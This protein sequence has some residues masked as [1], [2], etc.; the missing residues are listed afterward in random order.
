MTRATVMQHLSF[1]QKTNKKDVMYVFNPHICWNTK[2]MWETFKPIF[3]K[4][5]LMHIEKSA[6][7]G[8]N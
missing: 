7:T 8:F 4:I 5:L 1:N 2:C 6:D 3:M